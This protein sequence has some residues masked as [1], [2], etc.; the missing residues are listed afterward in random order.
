MEYNLLK[1]KGG[2]RFR[3]ERR[4]KGDN[5]SGLIEVSEYVGEG[6]LLNLLWFEYHANLCKLNNYKKEVELQIGKFE[7]VLDSLGSV[8]SNLNVDLVEY[9]KDL[10]RLFLVGS[11]SFR[12][13]EEKGS[14]YVDDDFIVKGL[15]NNRKGSFLIDDDG[16]LILKGAFGKSVYL[17]MA[18]ANRERLIYSG[19][20]GGKELMLMKVLV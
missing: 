1:E 3:L 10:L 20:S 17:N 16:R 2:D 14:I 18:S 6:D 7:K 13:G 8:F 12:I 4:E 19:I 9:N 15:G 5:G 11:W